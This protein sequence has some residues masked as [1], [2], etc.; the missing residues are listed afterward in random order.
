MS[1]KDKAQGVLKTLKK[2]KL[3]YWQAKEA[4]RAAKDMTAKLPLGHSL[5]ELPFEVK[6]GGYK[7][8]DDT[9]AIAAEILHGMDGLTAKETHE[10]LSTAKVLLIETIFK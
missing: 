6:P 5:P 10:I 3:K 4:L 9:N 8:K 1:I 2:Y 7:S